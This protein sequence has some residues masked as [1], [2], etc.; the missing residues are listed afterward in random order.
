MRMSGVMVVLGAALVLVQ[1]VWPFRLEPPLPL[2]M[3]PILLGLLALAGGIVLGLARGTAGYR[4]AITVGLVG[5]AVIVWGLTPRHR[6]PTLSPPIPD[7]ALVTFL[8]GVGICA[9]AIVLGF[10]AMW[11]ASRQTGISR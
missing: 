4:T 1:I 9:L 2:G 3:A 11:R 10:V 7:P 6:Q 8:I 5:V